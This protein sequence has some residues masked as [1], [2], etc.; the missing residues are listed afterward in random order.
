MLFVA[1]VRDSPVCHS[2]GETNPEPGGTVW[3]SILDMDV[4][5]APKILLFQVLLR[6]NRRGLSVFQLRP[7]VQHPQDVLPRLRPG[8]D[9]AITVDG[10]R[11][12]VICSQRQQY[13]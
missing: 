7:R 2:P 5:P 13:L 4:L 9:A 1:M 11:T 6:R 3:R 8:R 12:C 10:G